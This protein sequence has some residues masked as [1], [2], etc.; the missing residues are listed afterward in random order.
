IHECP[1]PRLPRRASQRFIFHVICGSTK[2]RFPRLRRRPYRGQVKAGIVLPIILSRASGAHAF[3][4]ETLVSTGGHESITMEALRRVRAP[5]GSLSPMV[6]NDDE[7]AL[8]DDLPFHVDGDMRDLA[9]G[10]LLVAVRDN[11][12][13]GRGAAELDQLAEVHGDP[14]AQ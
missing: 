6:P 10:T 9:S 1:C 11:D 4:I 2:W 7:R 8:L 12:L 5:P 14:S 3:T 13:K